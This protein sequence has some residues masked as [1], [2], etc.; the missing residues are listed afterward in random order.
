[1]T[2][3]EFREMQQYAAKRMLPRRRIELY[4]AQL[5]LVT[6]RGAGAK[7][8]TLDDFLFDPSEPE[9]VDAAAF[10]GFNPRQK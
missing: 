3:G 4:L 1:M 9:E 7:E 5:A 10:F 8:V 6:A 2:E